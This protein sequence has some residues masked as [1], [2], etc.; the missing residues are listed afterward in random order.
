MLG[1]PQRRLPIFVLEP[2]IIKLRKRSFARD[3]NSI[4]KN[5]EG[6]H[7]CKPLCRVSGQPL[8]KAVDFGLQPL[9]NGFLLPKQFPNEYFYPMEMGFSETSMML[10]LIEQPAP[11]QMFHE[12]YSFYSSTSRFM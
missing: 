12:Q 5:N 11:E 2:H 8:I 6:N 9:G 10:Q 1:L 3:S 4:I 7:M